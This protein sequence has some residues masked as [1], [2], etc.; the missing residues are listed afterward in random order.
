MPSK[1]S[2]KKEPE[3][4]KAPPAPEKRQDP[5][6]Q[7]TPRNFRVGGDI[8]PTRDLSRFVKWPRY[9][10][11]QRQRKILKERLK[12]PPALQQFKT[13]LDKNQATELLKLCMKYQPEDKAAKQDRLKSLAESGKREEKAPHVIKFGLLHMVSGLTGD[14]LC[15]FSL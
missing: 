9:V 6:F 14:Q 2:S 8:R 4:K 12:I 15:H 1:K 3:K 10:R 11:L 5:L 13:T 7:A